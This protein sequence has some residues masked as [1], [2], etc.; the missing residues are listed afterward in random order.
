ML[1]AMM[2]PR[3]N[4]RRKKVPIVTKKSPNAMPLHYAGTTFVIIIIIIIK[5]CKDQHFVVH[6][7]C[8]EFSNVRLYSLISTI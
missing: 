8:W 7:A 6:L 3:E 5:T 1:A 4:F 2:V